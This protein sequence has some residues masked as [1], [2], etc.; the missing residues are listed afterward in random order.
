MTGGDSHKAEDLTQ[1]TFTAAL[2]ALPTFRG[3]SSLLTWLVAICRRQWLWRHRSE[4]R[5]KP[6][7]QTDGVTEEPALDIRE[8]VHAA[9]AKLEEEDRTILVLF[10]LEGMSYQDLTQSLGLPLGSVKRRLHEARKKLRF[11]IDGRHEV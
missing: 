11:L 1:E 8:D 9:L 7:D 5:Y 4:K 3:D 2:R 6:L 10:H